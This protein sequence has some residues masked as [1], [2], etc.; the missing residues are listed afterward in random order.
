MLTSRLEEISKPKKSREPAPTK[1]KPVKDNHKTSSVNKSTLVA[2]GDSIDPG[3]PR[4]APDVDLESPK[5]SRQLMLSDDDYL[6]PAQAIPERSLTASPTPSR[7]AERRPSALSDTRVAESELD[8][9]PN[10][11]REAADISVVEVTQ[12]RA[13]L[14]LLKKR[15][16]GGSGRRGDPLLTAETNSAPSA[17]PPEPPSP[18]PMQR[19][20][21]SRENTVGIV[22][23]LSIV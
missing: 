3:K 14:Q 6:V 13:S 4:V 9:F 22:D 19:E 21:S 2:S 17:P 8:E 11:A 12:V 23:V 16:R 18:A 20:L 10:R 15:P 1:G 7:G 5:P